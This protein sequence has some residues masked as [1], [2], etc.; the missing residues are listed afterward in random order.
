MQSEPVVSLFNPVEKLSGL[1]QSIRLEPNQYTD[2]FSLI[3]IAQAFVMLVTAG[4]FL[5]YSIKGRFDRGRLLTIHWIMI[6]FFHVGALLALQDISNENFFI[7]RDYTSVATWFCRYL[8]IA[9]L[10]MGTF[11][12]YLGNSYKSSTLL[13]TVFGCAILA[14]SVQLFTVNMEVGERFVFKLVPPAILTGIVYMGLGLYFCPCLNHRFI[15]NRKFYS[16]YTLNVPLLLY[17]ATQF[18]FAYSYSNHQ[19]IVTFNAVAILMLVQIA[20]QYQIGMG[21]FK[22]GLLTQELRSKELNELVL[23]S[24]KY[25]LVGQL[26]AGIAH[27]LNNVLTLVM[28]SA[29]LA[30]RDKGKGRSI[31]RHLGKILKG[32]KNGAFL[33]KKLLNLSRKKSSEVSRRIAFSPDEVISDSKYVLE[34][35]LPASIE[36]VLDL[37]LNGRE[38]ITSRKEFEMVLVNLVINAKDALSDLP[39]SD[40]RDRL[41]TIRSELENCNDHTQMR[42]MKSVAN[43]AKIAVIDNGIGMDAKTLANA[44]EFGFTTKAEKGTGLGL[45]NAARFAEEHGGWHQIHSTANEETSIELHIPIKSQK[46]Q[47]RVITVGFDEGFIMRCQHSDW[48]VLHLGVEGFKNLRLSETGGVLIYPSSWPS[49]AEILYEKLMQSGAPANWGLLKIEDQDGADEMNEASSAHV[50]KEISQK[51]LSISHSQNDLQEVV[52]ELAKL[53]SGQEVKKLAVS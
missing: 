52:A 1:I 50:F 37:N 26:S 47:L 8:S 20:L 32:S 53:S 4:I 49:G 6:A 27:D 9:F 19:G 45:S 2:L 28:G 16:S 43:A 30:K 51:F 25:G 10:I 7:N 18:Y 42:N 21:F 14:V 44:D 36:L 3:Y 41:I 23:K 17:A 46:K 48:S 39:D 13:K 22:V 15:N 38:I 34:S 5:H 31:D 35:A 11:Q 40:A 12:T 24:E 33:T 29:E